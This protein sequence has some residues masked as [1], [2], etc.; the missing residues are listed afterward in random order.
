MVQR[1]AITVFKFLL[2][3]QKTPH[4]NFALG[5]KNYVAES[6]LSCSAQRA[7][8]FFSQRGRRYRLREMVDGVGAACSG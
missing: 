4:F 2:S 5:P 3:E 7:D 6:W 1:S 8:V